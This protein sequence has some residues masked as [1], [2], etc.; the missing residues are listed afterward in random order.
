MTALNPTTIVLAHP[1][2]VMVSFEPQKFPVD[3]NH[4]LTLRAG[5]SQGIGSCTPP[6][7]GSTIGQVPAMRNIFPVLGSGCPPVG[8]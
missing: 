4:W 7:P 8:G 1:S 5:R 6:P 3:L 2:V